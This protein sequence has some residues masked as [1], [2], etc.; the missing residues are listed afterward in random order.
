MSDSLSPL[1]GKLLSLLP[2]LLL[3]ESAATSIGESPDAVRRA[4]ENLR[5]AGLLDVSREELKQYE[6]TPDGVQAQRAGLP[7]FRLLAILGDGPKPLP[8][9][10]AELSR[11]GVGLA[12]RAN[13]ISID[14][15]VVSLT[16]DGR[17]ALAN[18]ALF[19]L[20]VPDM[21]STLE[22]SRLPEMVR[23]GLVRERARIVEKL[24]I[25]PAGQKALEESTTAL[26]APAASAASSASADIAANASGTPSSTFPASSARESSAPSPRPAARAASES[27]SVISRDHLLSGE[28]KNHPIRR[29]DLSAPPEVRRPARRHP[30]ARVEGSIRRIFM[31]MGFEEMA[32]P[33]VES[34]FFNFDAL[35]QPQDHPARD[36]ADTFYL[37]GTASRPPADLAAKVK[38]AHERG[39]SYQWDEKI[40]RQ[41]CLRTHTTAV[42]ARTLIDSADDPRPRK[43]FSI[44]KVFRNEATDYKHLAEFYQVEGIV[45]WE[46]ATFGHLLG[47]L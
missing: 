21:L 37:P 23:R 6:Y 38:S 31:N 44:G 41:L 43:F 11:V 17:A 1:E 39:W 46:K 9:L 20:P 30:I 32:G 13:W 3:L 19:A 8:Q 25:T 12:R 45:V 22:P 16:D 35:F 26:F 40:A 5:A 36:L 42:S 29:Y 33:L 2:S 27:I 28:W 47:L 34:A 18:A 7:E 24:S 14:A 15:G 4:T 10:P